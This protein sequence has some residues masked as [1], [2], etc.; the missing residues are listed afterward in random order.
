MGFFDKINAV[1]QKVG[2]VQRALL[3]AIVIACVLTG[4][5]L[6]RWAA[7]PEMRLLFG[8]LD[9]EQAAK[10]ADKISEQ[11]IPYEIRGGGG[12]IFVPAEN[13]HELRA[14]LAKD[15]LLPR[16]GDPGYEIFDNEKLGV[17]PLVQKLNYNRALQ[18]ELARTIQVFE[19]VEYARVHIVRPEQTMFTGDDQKA[20]ASVMLKLK[21]GWRIG[22]PTITAITNLVAGAVEGLNSDQVTVA[23]SQGHM[24]SHSGNQ[25]TLAAG[26]NNYLDYQSSVESEMANR[27]QRSLEQ[28]LGPGRS[29]VMVKAMVDM[30]SES[31][32]SKVYEKGI[33][34]EETIDETSTVKQTV[35]EG[36][37]GSQALPGSTEKSGTTTTQ[38]MLPE[39]ITTSTKIPGRVTGWSV[40]VM[41]DLTK[42][43]SPAAEGE[44]AAE[45]E[46]ASEG[47]AALIMTLDDVK[48][49]IRTAIGPELL[50]EQ[51]LTVKHVPFYRPAPMPAESGMDWNGIIEIARQLSM[52]ILAISAL[53]VLRIFTRAGKKASR[54]TTSHMEAISGGSLPMLPGGTESPGAMRK[55]IAGQLQ[56]NPEQVRMLFS[57]WLAEDQ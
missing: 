2:L 53:L 21:P 22:A 40:S 13:V 6:T 10:I 38:Y 15:G 9:L 37:E 18:G 54:E 32:V 23:D 30:S 24:L 20:S 57:S 17:S 16:D 1:W 56:Q 36:E 33:P 29:T 3:A 44:A 39:T 27:L 34:V 14:A 7:R 52:G 5:L 12:S 28:V 4:V 11:N 43:S 19:G 45:G 35:T 8:N 51:N 47:Q 42:T 26:A 25:D 31:V 49:I 46:T 50:S 41:V 55:L 48:E